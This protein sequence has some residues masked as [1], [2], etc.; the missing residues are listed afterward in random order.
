MADNKNETMM[1]GRVCE[2]LGD[3]GGN[4]RCVLDMNE[5]SRF[6]VYASLVNCDVIARLHDD[7]ILHGWDVEIVPSDAWPMVCSSLSGS[8]VC[9]LG[10]RV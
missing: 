2:I 5:E 10:I 1:G 3:V 9:I 8:S 4:V 7:V 6:R